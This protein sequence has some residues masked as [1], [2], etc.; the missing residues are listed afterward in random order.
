[1]CLC[2]E[3]MGDYDSAISIYKRLIEI[4]PDVAEYHGNLANILYMK[5]E[6]AEA[7]SHYQNAIMLHPSPVWTSLIAQTLGYVYQD[8]EKNLD[9]SIAAYQTAYML[10]PN[11]I[12]IYINLGSAYYDKGDFDNAL[13]VYRKAIELNPM[14]PKIHCNLGYLHWGKGDIENAIKEYELSIRYDSNYDIAYN[15]LGVIYL[16][17]LGHVKKAA[18]MFQKAIDCNANYA[19]AYYNLARSTAIMGDKIEADKLYQ[20]AMN[21]NNVTNEMDPQDITDRIQGLF[22]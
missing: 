4:Q 13:T 11:D 20:L 12:E 14:N 15:N 2:Y 7:I 5:G 1:M 21:V 19:L 22:D 17:D 10:T 9:A 8:V 6:L 3:E 16:D 18:E